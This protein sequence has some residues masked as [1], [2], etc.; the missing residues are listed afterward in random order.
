L[1][2]FLKKCYPTTTSFQILPDGEKLLHAPPAKSA[3]KE[4]GITTL[5][6]WPKY[7]PDLNPQENVW[8]WAE[9]KLRELETNDNSFLVFQKLCLKAVGQN[10][11]K[12]KLIGSMTKRVR[13]MLERQ[14]RYV[15]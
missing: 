11:A 10:P 1:G 8:A 2:P 4:L 15:A 14:G 5:P 12:E 9:N 13:M 3:Y 7:S 6:K